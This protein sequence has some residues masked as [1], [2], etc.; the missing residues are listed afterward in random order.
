MK[1]IEDR[2]EG[3]KIAYIG[4]GS[5][6]WAWGLMSDLAVESALSGTVALYDIDK[7]AAVANEI[8]G[9]KMN[10]LEGA[11]SHW[12]Y[13]AVDSL[14]EALT[15]ANF[16]I[17]S[18]MPGTFKEMRSDVHTPQ[19]YGIYQSVGDTVGPGG[20]MRALRTVPMYVTIAEAI[21]KYSPNAWVINYTNPMSICV[22]ALY[23]VFPEIKAF[24]CC[25]EVFGT[26]KILA[27]MLKNMEGIE[28]IA[29]QD[30][31]VNVV[32]IN[33]FTWFT[34]ATYMGQDLFPLYEKFV[35]KYYESGFSEDNK[36]HWMNNSFTSVQR[37]KFDL[38][39]RFG[40]IAAAGDRHLAEFVKGN[41]YLKNP[42]TVKSWKFGLTTVDWRENQL[43]ERLDRSKRLVSGEETYVFKETG[44]DGVRQ[45]KAL[46]GLGDLIT[47]VNIP[48]YGQIPNLP[49]GSI[50]ETNAVFRNDRV[51]P[52][53]AGNVPD[54]VYG[55]ITN[56]IS[57]QNAIT[58]A[59]LTND[60]KLMFTAFIND[61]LVNLSYEDART[62]FDEMVNNTSQYI[63]KGF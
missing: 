32:G 31:K 59:A 53:M 44:E 14:E 28:N 2:V 63:N 60:R 37:V 18:I 23:K 50:V 41:W 51:E 30:I 9:N 61:P 11:K 24:G 34:K 54:S 45:M 1:Y 55:M 52:I 22:N 40:W 49:L 43:K 29:R 4:G 38:F 12:N 15:D 47:N 39:R 36:D 6:G 26:Q 46:L 35:D 17:I 10:T 57:N 13:K 16:V 5:R 33:H 19:M 58:K 25:H 27:K 21:K 8:I 3:V 42:E 62:L 7:E 56:H 48:N 20:L